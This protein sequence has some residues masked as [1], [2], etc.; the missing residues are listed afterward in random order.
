[1]KIIALRILFRLAVLGSAGVMA[2]CVS[3]PVLPDPPKGKGWSTN[4][5]GFHLMTA[6]VSSSSNGNTTTTTQSQ[7]LTT[8]NARHNTR[9]SAENIT[10]E[11]SVG[12]LVSDYEWNKSLQSSAKLD[13]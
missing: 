2:G 3:P 8:V 13:E 7:S 4:A 10:R 9:H 1:M 11:L 12:H 5:Q 6:T